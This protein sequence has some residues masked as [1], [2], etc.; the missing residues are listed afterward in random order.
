MRTMSIRNMLQS[1]ESKESVLDLDSDLDH[2]IFK[3][4]KNFIKTMKFDEE[5]LIRKL[6]YDQR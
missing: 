2:S 4:T 5:N 1:E 6:T 3:N